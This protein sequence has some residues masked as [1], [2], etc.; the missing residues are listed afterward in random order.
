MTAL[1]RLSQDLRTEPRTWLITGCAGFIGSHLLET[2]LQ[3]EQ[4]VIGLDD[5]STGTPHNFEAVRREVGEAAWRRF[6]FHEGSIVDPDVCRKATRDVDYVLHHAGFI[7]VP[8]SIEDPIACHATNVTGTLHLLAAA[9]DNAVRR[10]IYATSSAVYGD[11][12]HPRKIESAIGTP[13][14][15][16]G[17]SKLMQELYAAVF[18][19]RYGF[20]TV[21]LRY[22][23]IFGPRQ[24]P[25]G[26]Y[27][28]VIPQW[29]TALMNGSAC[30]IYGDGSSTRD[31][32]HVANV[33]QANLL[34]ATA[35]NPAVPGQ[36][37][38]VGLG[39]G[40][41]LRELHTMIAAR[42]A[43]LGFANLPAPIHEL[44]RAG[45]IPHSV[46]DIAKIRREIAFE[47][48]IDVDAGLA[49]TVRSYAAPNVVAAVP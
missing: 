47:P 41:T 1:A 36:V 31:Y 32:C 2:L 23:N 13:L 15:P 12:A 3:L 5:F 17:A 11:D 45:D 38:N 7:S 18:F 4:R 19:D 10:L 8:L 22:F 26:G 44:P 25:E 20:E 27:A 33:V 40:T 21:G 42:V 37:F 49:E 6:H 48:Q 34:A 30:R 35:Q 29:I 39:A 9:R 16:Y 43:A 28:A 14:S 24:N 46:A